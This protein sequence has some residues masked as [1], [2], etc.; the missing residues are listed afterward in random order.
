MVIAVGKLVTGRLFPFWNAFMWH[1]PKKAMQICC[2]CTQAM[3]ETCWCFHVV[4]LTK[5]LLS[6]RSMKNIFA[7]SIYEIYILNDNAALWKS[8]RFI[9]SIFICQ[10]SRFNKFVPFVLFQISLPHQNIMNSLRK[11]F[12]WNSFDVETNILFLMKCY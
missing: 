4:W 5:P 1:F 8:S 12:I 7:K 10:Q 3:H 2:R 6:W 9:S 11:L